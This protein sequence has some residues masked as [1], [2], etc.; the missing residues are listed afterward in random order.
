MNSILCAIY[1]SVLSAPLAQLFQ[2]I[3]PPLWGSTA[4]FATYPPHLTGI[5]APT[6]AFKVVV[7]IKYVIMLKSKL[8][9]K[10]KN[11]RKE[12]ADT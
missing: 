6:N 10:L 2:V 12:S 9:R 8:K 5:F 4:I 11:Q 7:R 1:S 3:I